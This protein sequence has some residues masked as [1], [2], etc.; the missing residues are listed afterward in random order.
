MIDEILSDIGKA[1]KEF[2]KWY[3]GYFLSYIERC[4][5]LFSVLDEVVAEHN[6][7]VDTLYAKRVDTEITKLAVNYIE[8][9]KL[10]KFTIHELLKEMHAEKLVRVNPDQMGVG[11]KTQHD[12]GC[13]IPVRHPKHYQV[14]HSILYAR[15]GRWR[16][17]L[18]VGQIITDL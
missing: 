17:G 16:R 9:K 11:F 18:E 15:K 14:M 5:R 7:D 8:S 6:T 4:G 13:A 2:K 10:K 1:Y 12:M 3:E